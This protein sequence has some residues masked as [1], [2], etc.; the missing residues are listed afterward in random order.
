[1]NKSLS[2]WLHLPME[3]HLGQTESG[4]HFWQVFHARWGQVFCARWGQTYARTVKSVKLSASSTPTPKSFSKSF[5]SMTE[6]HGL[7][8]GIRGLNCVLRQGQ[9]QDRLWRAY[10]FV[11]SLHVWHEEKRQ[12]KGAVIVL[13]APQEIGA[14][15]LKGVQ[16]L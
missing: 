14:S 9:A 11:N 4:A 3:R 6:F 1:M 10:G 12:L 8:W 7:A 5:P 13:T 15:L 16:E 2:F